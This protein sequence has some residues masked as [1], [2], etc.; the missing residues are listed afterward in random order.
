LTIASILALSLPASATA[1]LLDHE[2][3][4][5]GT[6]ESINLADEYGGKVVLVV[7]TAS[8]CAFTDQ[9][10]GLEQLYATYRNRGFVV[11]GFP[12]G[13]FGNQ[14]FGSEAQI[15]DFC[16]LTYGV[17]FPMFEKLRVS[18][19]NAD[20][21]FEGLGQAAGRYPQWNFHKY[22]IDRDGR[23]VDNYLSFVSPQ[24]R[25]L[26]EAIEALL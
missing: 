15:K 12:S 13:D 3:R 21:V 1:A 10:E 20:P 19:G 16:R 26:I 8:R 11:L 5:L 9:Y 14:E 24:N 6:D 17:K 18:K 7:N 23:L 22:L 4:R 25:G 2:V